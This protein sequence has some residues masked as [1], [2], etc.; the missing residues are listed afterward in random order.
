M[1]IDKRARAAFRATITDRILLRRYDRAVVA[2]ENAE[3]D[4]NEARHEVTQTQRR[5]RRVIH[6]IES[7]QQP[8]R[9]P[10]RDLG[11]PAYTPPRREPPVIVNPP[12]GAGM[13][14]APRRI[15]P[16]QP[17]MSD[18]TVHENG[19]FSVG[20][21][22]SMFLVD[23]NAADAYEYIE[24]G[25]D[26]PRQIVL[27]VKGD[28]GRVSLGHAYSKHSP[29]AFRSGK[30]WDID[31]VF[32]GNGN[33][34]KLGPLFLGSKEADHGVFATCD[35][36]L[37]FNVGVH[38]DND[39]YAF[40]QYG[41]CR[42]FAFVNT[43]VVANPE[44]VEGGKRIHRSAFLLHKDW[45]SFTLK[46]YKPLDQLFEEHVCYFQGG[47]FTQVLDSNLYGGRRT[48]YQ[49]RPHGDGLYPSP[50]THGD[51]IA[52]GNY[53]DGFGWNH[54]KESGGNWLTNWF[55][56]EYK[57]RIS[58]NRCVDARYGCL[59]I[60]RGVDSSEPP[61]THDNLSHSNVYIWGNEFENRR[62]S[63]SC[64]SI[65][66]ARMV[67][68]GED[69]DFIGPDNGSH[70]MT[71]GSQ[72]GWKFAGAKVPHDWAWYGELAL[73]HWPVHLYEADTDSL[74]L[75]SNSSHSARMV[76]IR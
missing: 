33:S 47:G 46:G 64:V 69:N 67:H 34:S 63:R 60:S 11:D 22:G 28:I 17:S 75:L 62:A 5:L 27:R 55:S 43:W 74:K 9:P 58:N 6:R 50:A 30:G 26:T 18:A 15:D 16:I 56:G 52:D 39:P 24:G 53:S 38:A 37:F 13:A 41:Y 29:D 49:F 3:D 51:F 36:A 21:G 42:E 12:R 10:V 32:I 54:D 59:G 35:R 45:E 44:Y 1:S 76:S 70:T 71:L 14:G 25:L 23:G 68:F 2:L 7:A 65:A 72:W 19:T 48:G 20:V 8:T 73:P 31:V 57:V 66:D 40:R 61:V 4:L